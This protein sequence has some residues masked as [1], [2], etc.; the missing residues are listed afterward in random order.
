MRIG[1]LSA[2]FGVPVLGT[3]GASVH[4]RQMVR[5][6]M[7]RGHEVLVLTP[8]PGTGSAEPTGCRIAAL[9]FA[10]VAAVLHERLK[11]EPICRGNRL[12][13]DLRNLLYSAWLEN[14]AAPLLH[15][16]Q[17]DF[18]YERYSLFGVA[19]LQLARRLEVPLILEVNAPLIEEQQ[20]QRGLSLPLVATAAQRLVFSGADE[21][22]V[23]SRWLEEYALAHGAARERVTVI[24]NGAD[25]DLFRPPR[26]PSAIRRRLNWE[27]AVVLGFVGAMKSWHGVH[28]VVEAL[29]RLGGS[30]SAFRLLLVGDGPALPAVR[31]QVQA[32]GLIDAVHMPGAVPHHEVPEWLG[33]AD[34]ALVPYDASAAAYFSPVKLFECM[35]MGLPVV[36]ARL[37][38]TEEIIAHGRTG[39][40]YS[41]SDPDE[42]AATIRW[43]S[44]NRS[45]ARDAGAAARAQVLERHTWTHNAEIVE[46][47]ALRSSERRRASTAS[48]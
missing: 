38:Q 5:A 40:L 30:R 24:P 23:V 45:A 42:P 4:L 48:R 39:W 33:A 12:S 44:E 14:R 25:P 13:K 28:T 32:Q 9:P 27:D 17:P 18:L 26:G 16:F 10:D 34:V 36:A 31:E 8:N 11:E 19:G 46:R 2:D 15:E 29:K 21:V 47:L 20:E 3:K 1:Y 7:E 41:A 6:L 37:G 35:S 22:S 43:I